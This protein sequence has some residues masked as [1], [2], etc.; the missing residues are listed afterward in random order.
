MKQTFQWGG[1][2]Q[3]AFDTL[4]RKINNT[5]VLALPDLQ[6]PFEIDIDAY[7]HSIGAILKQGG[8]PISYHFETLV[9][10]KQH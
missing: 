10:A 8:H 3:N 7:Q 5:T 6:Q 4:K 9:Q 1:K 2:Q